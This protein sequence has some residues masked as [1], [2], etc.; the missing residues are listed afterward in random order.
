MAKFRNISTT[1]WNDTKV[2]EDMTPDEKYLF[3]YLLTNP[4]TNLCGC[5]EIG[6]RQIAY[7]TGLSND[8]VKKALDSLIHKHCV[9]RY[10]ERTKEMLIVNWH[11]HN[12][13]SSEKF[14]KPLADQINKVK[15]TVYRQFL[16]GL[17]DGDTV[18]IPYQY[19]TDT[20]EE[21]T[22]ENTE[23]DTVENTEE[24]KPKAEPLMVASR[25]IVNY[26]NEKTHS[27]YKAS[28]RNTVSLIKARMAEGHTTDDFKKVIDVKSAEWLGTDQ[29]QYLRPE[30]LFCAKHFESY[31]N[32]KMPKARSGTSKSIGKINQTIGRTGSAKE[33]NDALVRQLLAGGA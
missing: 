20:T 18:S 4:L 23:E 7:D 17:L 21:Y 5:Y 25:E 16:L 8:K 19:G 9:V 28:S 29:E 26:L 14:R 1:F 2:S 31:L 24:D 3:L 32:Q 27:N 15:N 22:E 33:Q 13:T 10:S 11:K 30:T 6:M 12:W